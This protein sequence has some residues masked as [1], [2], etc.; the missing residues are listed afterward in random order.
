[1]VEHRKRGG[2]ILSKRKPFAINTFS[3]LTPWIPLVVFTEEEAVERIIVF[4]IIYFLIS[5]LPF[6]CRSGGLD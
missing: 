4:I 5:F 1:M 2:S 3:I 6:D